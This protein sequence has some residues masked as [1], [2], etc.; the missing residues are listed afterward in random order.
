MEDDPNNGS[1]TSDGQEAP[2]PRVF[3]QDD[4]SRMLAREKDEGRRAEREAVARTLGVSVDEAKKVIEE[5]RRREQ[6]AKTEAEKSRERAEQERKEAEAAQSAAAKE[7]YTTRVQRALLS[8]KINEARLDKAARLVD[9]EVGDDYDTI[10]EAVNHL[11]AEMPELFAAAGIPDSDPR[12]A[13][14][15]KKPGKG[16]YEA[17]LERA[18]AMFPGRA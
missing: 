17:G 3:T 1:N 10:T 2:P 18:K 12:S 7:V 6:E 5:S 11:K 16:S 4:V 14:G 13:G 9:A 15:K 8:A